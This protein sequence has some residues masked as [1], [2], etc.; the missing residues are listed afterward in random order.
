MDNKIQQ[1][2]DIQ[3]APSAAALYNEAFGSKFARAIPN[4]RKRVEIITACLQPEFSFA[5]VEGQ[6]II[7][8]AGF[9]TP[10]GSLTGGINAKQ[11]L[12]ALGVIRG[13]WACAVFS[14]FERKPDP[15]ELVMD[16]IV[17]S[18]EHR[19]RGIGT[20]LLDELFNYA[21]DNK[22]KT[23]RLD[24]IDTNPRA[25]KLYESKGFVATKT[26]HFPYLK[27]LIGF[28]GA[29]TMVFTVPR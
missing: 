15:G 18:A 7:G 13:L 9:Q 2:W 5:A 4:S 1:G 11:L 14:L 3:H 6:Q 17:V 8:L 10:Q 29:T 28:S 20:Q 16:G 26:E 23:I 27:W 22:F 19:G 25:R 21:A 24:V 12:S